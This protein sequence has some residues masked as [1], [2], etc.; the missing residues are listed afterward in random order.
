MDD[1]PS[2]E[3]YRLDSWKSIAA[4]LNRDIR[5]V[6]RWE[7]LGL[8]IRR[9]AGGRGRSVFAY[10][11][12]IDAWLKAHLERTPPSEPPFPPAQTKTL[13]RR[14]MA[15]AAGMLVIV[16]VAIVIWRMQPTVTANDLR[17]DTRP[18]GFVAVDGGGRSRWRYTTATGYDV[19]W[20]GTPP[21]WTVVAGPQPAV[22]AATAY[23]QRRIDQA[24]ESGELL[25]FD[26]RGTLRQTFSFTD[27]VRL[28]GR[29]YGRRGASR[30]SPSTSARAASPLPRT[31]ING[32]RAW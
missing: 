6:R 3:P 14:S 12:E 9:V 4:Y 24:V 15:V 31:I 11:S 27:R 28:E 17:I 21:R 18:D 16:V 1:G 10:A 26:I 22:F 23:R 20:S 7:A 30:P 5:T 19:I 13:R 32:R 25:S 8:P 2:S 29:E